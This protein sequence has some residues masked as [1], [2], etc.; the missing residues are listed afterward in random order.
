LCGTESAVVAAVGFVRF[1]ARWAASPAKR[2]MSWPSIGHGDRMAASPYVA[3]RKDVNVS[4]RHRWPKQF[5]V[6]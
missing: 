4:H 1:G 2:L 3:A 6:R 5:R